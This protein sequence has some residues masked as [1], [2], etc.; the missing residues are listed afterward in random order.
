M[1]QSRFHFCFWLASHNSLTTH[2][3]VA[4]SLQT[5]SLVRF[6]QINQ[7]SPHYLSH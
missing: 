4:M 6:P 1:I 5:A 2:I 3:S 7:L